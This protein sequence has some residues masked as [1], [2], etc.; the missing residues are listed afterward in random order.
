MNVKP[1][2]TEA[3]IINSKDKNKKTHSYGDTELCYVE[4]SKVLG[5]WL[6]NKLSWKKQISVTR[7]KVW[8]AWM[9]IRKLCNQHGGLRISTIVNLIKIMVLSRM[10]Y[11]APV[12]LY[13]HTDNFQDVWSD[14]LRTASGSSFNPSNAK[15]EVLTAIPPVKI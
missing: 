13:E 2:K 15:I 14:M 7:G 6:D 9:E 11:C 4:S 5:L 8:H 12:W 1:G 10:Y 3:M